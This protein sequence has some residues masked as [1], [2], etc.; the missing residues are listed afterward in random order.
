[1]KNQTIS[2]I[3]LTAAL[4]FAPLASAQNPRFRVLHNFAAYGS[5]TDGVI[6]YGPLIL[7]SKGNL[8]GVTIDGGA[9]QCS[10]YGCGI[11]FELSLENGGWRERILHSFAGGN[12]GS[13]PSGSLVLDAKSN[14]YATLLGNSSVN[15]SGV[16]EL[17]PASRGWTNTSLY[18]GYSGPGLISDA[19][20]KLYG[21]IGPGDYS[22]AGAIG[23]LSPGSAGWD[24]TQ[25][26]S[27][28]PQQNGC[29]DGFLL[30]VPPTWD[31]KGN[32]W[33]VTTEG[34]ISTSPCFTEKG[35]GV[36]FEMT[37]TG[38]GA[39]AYHVMHHFAASIYDG[40]WPYGSLVRDSAGNFYGSTWLGGFYNHG[41]VFKFSRS[42]GKWKET[43]LYDFPTCT[44]GCMVEGTLALDS[45]GNLY[46]T[47]AGGTNSCAGFSC[48]VVF[49]LAPQAN[50]RYKYS[51]LADFSESTGG[52]QP[53]Y[54]VILGG[55]GNLF[56]VTSSFG[57][58]GGGTAFEITP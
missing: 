35:C 16:F 21:S 49:K 30:N 12:D 9:G 6:P 3:A 58:Y 5:S 7:D 10:D 24:Y 32:L 18:N 20:G 11:V 1:M 15:V 57:K 31:A 38:S 56:G 26:Y 50:G 2:T 37:R 34:G 29:P 41:T 45:A 53:F 28:C 44:E 51:V 13:A 33:G 14:L 39:W 42:N 27:F 55:K 4:T 54:G 52:V 19:Q 46:G 17:T 43:I 48:G 22:G 40:Q 25:L 23:E 47:A 8:Y 36:I